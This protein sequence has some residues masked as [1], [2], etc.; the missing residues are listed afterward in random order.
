MKP[1]GNRVPNGN[2]SHRI[3][4][5]Y[6]VIPIFE[7]VTLIIMVVILVLDDSTVIGIVDDTLII[8]I[9]GLVLK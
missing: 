5:K 7:L 9:I 6:D 4:L 3:S 2:G 1:K 8:P